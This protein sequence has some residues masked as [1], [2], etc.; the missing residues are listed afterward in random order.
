M[1]RE[2]VG[3][4]GAAGEQLR[5]LRCQIKAMTFC[6][7]IRILNKRI[8]NVFFFNELMEDHYYALLSSKHH[9]YFTI[10][11]HFGSRLAFY[12]NSCRYLRSLPNYCRTFVFW[13]KNQFL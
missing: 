4:T 10:C 2:P 9:P 11:S 12:I 1:L 13:L 8:K 3:E 7:Q 5:E 6:V